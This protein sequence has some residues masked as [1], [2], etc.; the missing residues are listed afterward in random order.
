[1]SRAS[2]ILL[3]MK[4]ETGFFCWFP[5]FFVPVEFGFAY[6]AR[7]G[8]SR[9]ARCGIKTKFLWSNGGGGRKPGKP[10]FGWRACEP[11]KSHP[12]YENLKSCL[13]NFFCYL[14]EYFEIRMLFFAFFYIF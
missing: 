10:G 11:G 3:V 9:G 7:I 13:L 14:I 2:D 6:V 1:M 5:F 12:E 8:R 4:T